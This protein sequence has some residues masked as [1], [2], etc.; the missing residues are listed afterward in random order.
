M[1]EVFRH[2]EVRPNMLLARIEIPFE[3]YGSGQG[4]RLRSLRPDG[5]SVSIALERNMNVH[6]HSLLRQGARLVITMQTTITAGNNDLGARIHDRRARNDKVENL[7]GPT[8]AILEVLG[9]LSEVRI[10]TSGHKVVID[11]LFSIR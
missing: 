9:K 1:F 4:V 8:D 7:V 6:H 3:E 2:H 5:Y 10:S 11:L